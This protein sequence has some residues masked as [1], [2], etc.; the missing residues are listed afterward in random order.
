MAH[1]Y[2]FLAAGIVGAAL[3]FFLWLKTENRNAVRVSER[4][5]YNP[6]SSSKDDIRQQNFGSDTNCIICIE[7]EC[8]MLFLPCR[9]RCL[10]PECTTQYIEQSNKCP[11][12]RAVIDELM[13]L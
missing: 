7:R 13:C 3:A 11:L 4:R 10:C 1:P 2:A 12:C 9:H 6:Q 8:S 5:R